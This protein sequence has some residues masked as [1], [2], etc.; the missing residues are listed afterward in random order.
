[1][2]LLFSQL[3][4]L[5]SALEDVSRRD[6]PLSPARR[7]QRTKDIVVSW[8][9]AHKVSIGSPDADA[10]ALLSALFPAKRSDRVYNVQPPRLTRLL[11]SCLHLGSG[12]WRQ[13]HQWEK[14]GQGD[15]G[16]CVERV[17]RIAEFP[18]QPLKNEVTLSQVDAAFATLAARCRF[19]APKAR[20][21]QTTNDAEMTGTLEN[22]YQRLQS[23][24]AKWFTR[25]ILKDFSCLELNESMVYAI[26][27][28][29]LPVAMRMYDDFEAAVTELKTLL[30]SQTAD[31]GHGDWAQKLTNDTHLLV[32]KIGVKIGPPQW[33]KAKGGVKH[34]VT[35]IDGRRMS[36]ERKH[37]GEYCQIHVNLDKGEKCLQIFSKSGKDSTIDRTGV[38]DAIRDCLRI[39]KNNCGF[40]RKCILEG[41]L[42]IWSERTKQILPFHKIRKHVSRSGS[43]LGTQLDSQY[44]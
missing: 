13:L 36:I 43:F 22:V 38:H 3:C 24:E 11:R 1:M 33:L 23:R 25:L 18:S 20:D 27:D 34:A 6:P 12:R 16:D 15:L 30:A 8:F 9:K 35:I 14:P 37:D 2:P 40:S 21:L 42:L 5:F 31:A 32:P 4:D 17:L 19:S 39:G 41:E 7:Q 28:P 44:A 29:R 26:I 10:V